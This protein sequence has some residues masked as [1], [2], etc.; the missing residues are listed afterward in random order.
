MEAPNLLWGH[1]LVVGCITGTVFLELWKRKN[2]ELA[3]EWDVEQ[4]EENEPDR[5]SFSGTKHKK[6]QC[7]C[8]RPETFLSCFL[9]Q[10]MC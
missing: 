9:P 3:Y 7:N 2:A 8:Q 6:V 10:F 1:V 4:F 5:P